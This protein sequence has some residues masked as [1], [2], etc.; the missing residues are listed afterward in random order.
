[1]LSA[2]P[3]PPEQGEGIG[4]AEPPASPAPG[5]A[6]P[7]VKALGWSRDKYPGRHEAES[8]FGTYRVF[9]D[10]TVMLDSVQLSF[11]PGRPWLEGEAAAQ[12]DYERRILSTLEQD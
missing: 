1:M 6:E 2:A 11:M 5:P 7:V 9:A 12:A 8:L 10:G 4:L 3:P